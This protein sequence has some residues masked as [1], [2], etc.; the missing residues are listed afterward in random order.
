MVPVK[1]TQEQV[2]KNSSKLVSFPFKIVL[3][4]VCFLLFKTFLHSSVNLNLYKDRKIFK[5]KRLQQML[6]AEK[7]LMLNDYAKQYKMVKI[8]LDNL[9]KV[10]IFRINFRTGA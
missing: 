2:M 4:N 5:Q 7:L 1:I 10:C 6:A 9:F 3:T 8:L